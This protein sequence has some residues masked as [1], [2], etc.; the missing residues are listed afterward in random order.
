MSRTHTEVDLWF[1]QRYF[2][3]ANRVSLHTPFD[4]TEPEDPWRLRSDD[5]D[6]LAA[7][8]GMGDMQ[9]NH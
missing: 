2:P 4:L 8:R 7:M 6:D 5:C 1:V 9:W 3:G